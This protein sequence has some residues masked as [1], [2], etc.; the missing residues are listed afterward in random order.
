MNDTLSLL[1]GAV[2]Y[3]L[4]SL[5]WKDTPC[6]RAGLVIGGVFSFPPIVDVATWS[7]QSVYFISKDCTQLDS[8]RNNLLGTFSA[9]YVNLMLDVNVIISCMIL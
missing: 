9:W 1:M 6:L 4:A 3:V 2:V 7:L 8:I 5:R